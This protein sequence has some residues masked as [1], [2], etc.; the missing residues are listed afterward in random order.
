MERREKPRVQLRLK[1]DDLTRRIIIAN[2]LAVKKTPLLPTSYSRWY[3][4]LFFALYFPIL[5]DLQERETTQ[6]HLFWFWWRFTIIFPDSWSVQIFL[7][8]FGWFGWLLLL[9]IYRVFVKDLVLTIC[10]SI[11]ICKK[12]STK[13][14]FWFL[15]SSWFMLYFHI[16]S[17]G[18]GLIWNEVG[19]PIL[20]LYF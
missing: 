3:A 7:L 4:F 19:F 20:F 1:R 2:R 16:V 8:G 10:L 9:A 6:V 18:F 15:I 14:S 5:H 17:D 13:L 12:V 11:L